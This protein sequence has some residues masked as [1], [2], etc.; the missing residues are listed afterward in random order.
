MVLEKVVQ[1]VYSPEV[2]ET[3][4]SLFVSGARLSEIGKELSIPLPTLVGWTKKEWWKDRE[5]ELKREAA[6]QTSRKMKDVAGMALE[7]TRDRLVDGDYFYDQKTGETI[8][9]KVPMREAA[10]VVVALQREAREVER[11]LAQESKD[12]K[13]TL[14]EIR[15]TFKSFAKQIQKRP[16]V[17]VTD[18]ILG[19]EV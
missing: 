1:T 17:Q 3:V 2:K 6:L 15:E 9:K 12:I 4:L 13:A 8:R 5:D 11:P 14:D 10:K 19:K 7:V 18:V 16:V